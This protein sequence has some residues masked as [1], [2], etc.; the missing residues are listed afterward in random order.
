MTHL[1]IIYSALCEMLNSFDNIKT[2]DTYSFSSKCIPPF[3]F[4]VCIK[5]IP[6]RFRWLIMSVSMLFSDF[7]APLSLLNIN[8]A[9]KVEALVLQ[10]AKRTPPNIS[11]SK[12]SNAQR[13]ENKT[14]DVV[15]HQ[16][17]C[18]L[19]KMDILMSETF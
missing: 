18:R 11:R 14:T 3:F 5:I 8:A 16:H 15:I 19:L 1:R 12:N 13:T 4:A 7:S 17:S 6:F 2:H 10:P 9:E